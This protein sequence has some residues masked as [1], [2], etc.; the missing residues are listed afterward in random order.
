MSKN[1]KKENLE[2]VHSIQ[3][4]NYEL[5]NFIFSKIEYDSKVIN[6]FFEYKKYINEILANFKPKIE[7]LNIENINEMKK[8]GKIFSYSNS[9]TKIENCV[10]IQYNNYIKYFSE[11]V[12]IGSN[13]NE[14]NNIRASTGIFKGKFVFE[15][16]P[17]N[18][19]LCESNV[20]FSLLTDLLERKSTLG[21][22]KNS[23][24]FGFILNS[25]KKIKKSVLT[26]FGDFVNEGDV[27]G[28]CLDLDEGFCEIFINGI[29]YGKIFEKLNVD[30]NFV[31]YPTFS[32]HKNNGIFCNFGGV[33]KFEFEYKN[34]LPFD[35]IISKLNGVEII[36]I[37]FI[38]ILKKNGIKILNDK[39]INEVIKLE[40]FRKILQFLFD[41]S[42]NDYY[43]IS[44]Y[45]FPFLMENEENFIIFKYNENYKIN[46]EKFFE[47][48]SLEILYY[49]YRKDLKKWKDL[50]N[51]F[52]N[53]I[54]YNFIILEDLKENFIKKNLSFVFRS[55]YFNF[56]QYKIIFEEI[57]TKYLENMNKI[58]NEINDNKMF[59]ESIMNIRNFVWKNNIKE[60]IINEQIEIFQKILNLSFEDS[61][62][63]KH[64]KQIFNHFWCCN[65]ETDLELVF[66]PL[67]KTFLE[68]FKNK[69]V[70]DL[71]IN[72]WF[73]KKLIKKNENLGGTFDNL[74][75]NFKKKIPNF[76]E[77]KNKSKNFIS[78]IFYDI[79]IKLQKNIDELI[80]FSKYFNYF[81]KSSNLND[82]KNSCSHKLIFLLSNFNKNIYYFNPFYQ[83][84]LNDFINILL[85]YFLFLYEKNIIY[86]LPLK[87]IF[88]P[89]NFMSIFNNEM[90]FYQNEENLKFIDKLINFNLKLLSDKLIN[91][92]FIREKL[93]KYL[94][95]IFKDE[96]KQKFFENDFYLEKFFNIL[97][98]LCLDSECGK[99]VAFI[100]SK[101]FKKSKEYFHLETF[102]IKIIIF[103]KNNYQIFSFLF[104]KFN[105]HVNNIFSNLLL[106]IEEFEEYDSNN[107][108]LNVYFEEMNKKRRLISFIIILKDSLSLFTF[109]LKN[110]PEHIL[111]ENN[112]EL[113][114]LIN[115]ISNIS[116]RLF[117]K[118]FLKIIL[119]IT[120]NVEIEKSFI[121]LLNEISNIF[122]YLSKFIL[123]NNYQ[124]L[125]K[126][127]FKKKDE[128]NVNNLSN[129]FEILEK[130]NEL[131]EILDKIFI[132]KNLLEEKFKKF[133]VKEQTIKKINK[134]NIC[135]ICLESE[136][137][138]HFLP[139]NHG[140]CLLCL[141][142]YLINYNRCFL[143][144]TKIEKIKEDETIKIIE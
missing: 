45:I 103:F 67:I 108:N 13:M 68:S 2:S 132:T 55:F 32:L 63:K 104:E 31:Y 143:C 39:K 101:I 119:K 41:V 120:N 15:F 107:N 29:K 144:K 100:I 93:L 97:G 35:E 102:Y 126:I 49:S 109:S 61:S 92:P 118:E 52:Y 9:L 10:N 96:N 78:K 90:L 66:F 58:G 121:F 43:V 79:L 75:K 60:E 85:D 5:L 46:F 112:I 99:F 116:N 12:A 59:I 131:K 124:N 82:I 8:T 69:S 65:I 1:S 38:E 134:E 27:I 4:S 105:V 42:F 86:F 17:I 113:I 19:R 125:F 129:V 70:K 81:C 133:N 30:S 26:P 136:I 18:D 135:I 84:I 73:K 44:N 54:S 48:L 47:F 50:L 89:F 95:L 28:V 51:L 111:N 83:K 24:S 110:F 142:Q 106:Y 140:C 94:I 34:Y 57:E 14:F 16:M 138:H 114:Q 53:L 11:N 40:I 98:N 72:S 80:K 117:N 123:N 74:E 64:F 22:E 23:E 91:N 25:R 37:K 128:S 71:N 137:T 141:K 115:L 130:K 87:I 62:F 76:E 7:K 139:C 56:F 6:S 77:I 88:I 36:T 127:F 21:K 3:N 33:K 122:N 20:G